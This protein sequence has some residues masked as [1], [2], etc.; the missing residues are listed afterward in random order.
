MMIIKYDV[1][2][3]I[4][5]SLPVLE[6]RAYFS[7]FLFL[8]FFFVKIKLKMKKVCNFEYSIIFVAF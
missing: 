1:R 6:M 2:D 8:F 4:I 7:C 5:Y 3:Q